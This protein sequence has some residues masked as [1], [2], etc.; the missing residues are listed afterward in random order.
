MSLLRDK[1]LGKQV[2]VIGADPSLENKTKFI[3]K[4]RKYVRIVADG[5]V[6]AL[7]ENNIKPDIVVTDLDGN[8]SF[9][10]RAEKMGAIMPGTCPR[11]QYRNNKEDCA[12]IQTYYWLY[13]GNAS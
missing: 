1:I 5:A 13:T 4:N 2:M 11:R 10:Q 12:E 6:Q 9:L 7:I 8:S 3:K